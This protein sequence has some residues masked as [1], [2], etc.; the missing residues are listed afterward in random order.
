MPAM[1]GRRLPQPE[2]PGDEKVLSDIREFGF[3]AKHVRPDAHPEH[4]AE[5]EA[6]GPHP[7]YDIGFSYTVGLHHSHRHPELVITGGM[8][9]GTAH[10]ILWEVV[11]LIADGERFAPGDRSARVLRD[12]QVRF[13]PVT[14]RWRK[15]ILTFAD[16]AARRKPVEAVQVLLPDREGRYPGE[17]GYAG[18]PQPT[19][20]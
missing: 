3:H 8:S 20:G 18:P 10:E 19:L 16:W 7:V 1:F 14:E 11:N 5:K 9:D 2:D 4:A 12:H 13:G 6:F 17:E 15:E